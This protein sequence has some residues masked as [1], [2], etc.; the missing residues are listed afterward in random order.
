[1][2]KPIRIF[3][4]TFALILLVFFTSTGCASVLKNKFNHKKKESSCSLADLVGPDTYYY[5]DHYQRKLK[6]SIKKI[7]RK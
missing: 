6:K 4:Y 2:S 1:M 5:S 3:K 7:N